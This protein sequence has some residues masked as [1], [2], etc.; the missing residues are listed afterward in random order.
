MAHKQLIFGYFFIVIIAIISIT[1][2][3]FKRHTFAKVFKSLSKVIRNITYRSFLNRRS[4]NYLNA[5]AK[6][7]Q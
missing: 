1:I 4:N 2:D 3:S 5:V 7:G 6:D